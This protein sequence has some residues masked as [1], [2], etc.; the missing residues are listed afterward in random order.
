MATF[1]IVYFIFFYCV[2]FHLPVRGSLLFELNQP[3]TVR[4]DLD[5]RPVNL[6][7]TDAKN[8]SYNYLSLIP[9]DHCKLLDGVEAL[10]L[11]DYMCVNHLFVQLFCVL[12]SPEGV[13]KCVHGIICWNAQEKKMY[14][15]QEMERKILID[16]AS[17]DKAGFACTGEINFFYLSADTFLDL[18]IPHSE[19][20]LIKYLQANPKI[21][22]DLV[23]LN[24]EIAF[25]GIEQWSL[26]KLGVILYSSLD[27]CDQCQNALCKFFDSQSPFVQNIERSLRNRGCHFQENFSWNIVF[28]SSMPCKKS[29]YFLCDNFS[30]QA[31]TFDKDR[32]IF[33]FKNSPLNFLDFPC[34]LVTLDI[35][36]FNFIMLSQIRLNEMT[37]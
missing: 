37:Y 21:V 14:L 16:F 19:H 10:I 22:E 6:Y 26:E 20:L 17:R 25:S 34:S 9:Q 2:F 1:R 33:Y 27:S 3:S 28:F 35:K 13:L 12:T 4:F 5:D 18:E 36:D 29:S 23:D 8:L 11:Q 15:T 31:F 32:S 24:P 7:F 30:K